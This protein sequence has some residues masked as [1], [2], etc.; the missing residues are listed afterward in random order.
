[1]G[2]DYYGS[3]KIRNSCLAPSSDS[4]HIP[5][6]INT[7]PWVLAEISQPILCTAGHYFGKNCCFG[8]ASIDNVLKLLV[9]SGLALLDV[10]SSFSEVG[11]MVERGGSWWWLPICDWGSICGCGHVDVS[12]S[13]I[14]GVS[15]ELGSFIAEWSPRYAESDDPLCPVSLELLSRDVE[16]DINGSFPSFCILKSNTVPFVHQVIL[17]CSYCSRRRGFEENRGR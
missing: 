8:K 4:I 5:P 15:R 6:Y 9:S 16:P 7:P 1:M 17:Q 10:H 11:S 2:A 3:R 13:N 14:S 12:I